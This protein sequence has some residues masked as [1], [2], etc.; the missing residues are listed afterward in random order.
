[1]KTFRLGF[2]TSCALVLV[3]GG[4]TRA[5]TQVAS[6]WLAP[7][8][9][10]W[11][12]PANWSTTPSFP[13][14]GTPP[15]VNYDVAINKTGAPYTVTFDDIVEV[16]SVTLDSPDAELA[17][18]GHLTSN[19]FEL[20]SGNVTIGTTQNNP[21][22]LRIADDLTFNG[23][24]IRLFSDDD[25]LYSSSLNF[26]DQ[27][28][29]Q[30]IRGHGTIS[31]AGGRQNSL[32]AG[33][34]LVI[35]PNIV[36][37]ST[38]QDHQIRGGRIVN[39]G[40]IRAHANSSLDVRVED[41]LNK[42]VI[43]AAGSLSVGNGQSGTWKNEGTIRIKPGGRLTLFGDITVD[44][45]G[46][47][48]DEGAAQVVL[49]GVLDNTGRTLDLNSLGLTVP[50][51]INGGEI[52]GGRI[53][54]SGL[55]SLG[56]IPGIDA[57]L[58]GVT[59][60][61]NLTV[62]GGAGGPRIFVSNG[63]TLDNATLTMQEGAAM[64]FQGANQSLSGTGS[65][66][67]PDRPQTSA[68]TNIT[69]SELIIGEG[70]TIRNGTSPVRETVLDFKENRGTIIAEAPNSLMSIGR[71]S[72]WQNKGLIRV[73]DGTV[74]FSGNYTAT[75][76]GNV[77][78][79][80]GEV[81]LQGNLQN[82]GGVLSQNSSTGTWKFRGQVTGGRV[83]SSGGITANLG[84]NFDGVTLAGP[85]LVSDASGVTT[86]NFSIR[87][88]LTL[89]QSSIVVPSGRMIGITD[90][91]VLIDGA[92]EIVLDGVTS[93]TLIQT[94]NGSELT[95]GS[96]VTIRTGPNGGGTI[97]RSTLPVMNQG[98]ISAETK[99]KS[100][101][102]SGT[103]SNTGL[104][105]S[106]NGSQLRIDSNGFTNQGEMRLADGRITIVG[107]SFANGVGGVV[108]GKGDLEL[109]GT[110]L[111]N[112][113]Q[114]SPGLPLGQLAVRGSLVMQPSSSVLIELGGTTANRFD[115]ILVNVNAVLDGNL[116]V[117]ARDGFNLGLN[118]R[119]L[120]VNV[121]GSAAGQFAGLG[122]GAQVGLLND[123]ALFITYKAGNGN[124]VALFTAV[125][126]PTTSAA[127]VMALVAL[128]S[129]KRIG[130]QSKA[131]MSFGF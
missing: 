17:I 120:I 127:V 53:T 30:A 22:Q 90:H 97:S 3:A 34:E 46:T 27:S 118:Q 107:N 89:D 38:V 79:V 78:L 41:L 104:L 131:M 21:Y 111:T 70:I 116:V 57:H 88:R 96:G 9:G 36:V 95:V 128:V 63:L 82:A 109:A 60:A 101:I 12:S 4:V 84:G 39:E 18:R 33:K 54:S 100:L 32:Q 50:L 92:G 64:Y 80:G 40:L 43:E 8:S 6:E 123:R 114:L 72:A 44:D 45:I 51:S 11:T 58:N 119:F 65:I 73:L 66:V 102:V 67:T 75:D 5:A 47:V 108:T 130:R 87:N 23:T 86:G 81:V 85:A 62:Q 71:A 37:E 117:T 69:G 121:I 49:A 15:N 115:S 1:M 20:S 55:G 83:A 56:F 31:F 24:S 52:R 106:K 94:Y 105:Q 2:C 19:S 129:Y 10:S 68:I 26:I 13:K 61:T 14:N 35:G 125:P 48:I 93:N 25:I 74:S 103:V 91:P 113:G 110:P 42:G 28:A 59:V 7:A 126:E 112:F 76:I 124:D 16:T 99:D 29:P 98:T 77:E 122:E